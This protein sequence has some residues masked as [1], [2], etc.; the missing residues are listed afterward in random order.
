MLSSTDVVAAATDP[1]RLIGIGQR[2]ILPLA[3]VAAVVAA[4]QW[5]IARR[6]FEVR[7]RMTPQEHQDEVRSLQAD[8]KVRLM[9]EQ[10]RR[11]PAAPDSRTAR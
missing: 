10:T 4:I 8:P 2:A 7:I 1:V 11:S 9:R 3:A 6:R 5:V